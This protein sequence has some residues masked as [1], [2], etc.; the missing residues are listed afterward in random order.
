MDTSDAFVALGLTV[1]LIGLA[2]TNPALVLA[3]IGY[4]AFTYGMN[5]SR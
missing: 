1:L 3:L 2:L 4:A 5:R